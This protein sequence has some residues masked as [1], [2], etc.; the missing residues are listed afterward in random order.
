MRAAFGG[1]PRT[2]AGS[3]GRGCRRAGGAV[4]GAGDEEGR[5]E[6]LSVFRSMM[7]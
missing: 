6:A 4:E 7:T 1:R 3:G 5:N 2:G